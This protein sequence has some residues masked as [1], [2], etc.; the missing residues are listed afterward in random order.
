MTTPVD[1]AA[2]THHLTHALDGVDVVEAA[3]DSYFFYN[4]GGDVPADHRFPF[5]T[6]VTG[7]RH[8]QVSDLERPGVFR[9]NVGVSRE[10]FLRLFG[11]QPAPP[12][13]TGVIDT[14]HDFSAL[15]QLMPH[16]VYGNMYWLCVLNPSPGTW[17]AIQP[18]L[19]EAHQL[20][21]ARIG[22]R[23]PGA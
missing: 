13:G 12:K 8:D 11:S 7:D 18:L 15:D 6:L 1:E 19:E 22:R 14:G 3:G 9:L 20:A 5:V 23:A 16:P 17:D 2:I 4:P 10:T 21:A